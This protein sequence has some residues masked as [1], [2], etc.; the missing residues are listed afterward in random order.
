MNDALK[1]AKGEANDLI[2]QLES[3][4]MCSIQDSA[5]FELAAKKLMA[6]QRGEEYK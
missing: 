1:M 3:R 2:E 5:M 4:R 6:K